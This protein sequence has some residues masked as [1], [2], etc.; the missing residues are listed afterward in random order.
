MQFST[1]AEFIAMDGHGFYVWLSYGVSIA[2]LTLLVFFSIKTN[3]NIIRQIQRRQQR[4]EKLKQAAQQH[5]DS[6]S[7]EVTHESTS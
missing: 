4:E 2:L 1:F 3:K 6:I 7:Q 5:Q